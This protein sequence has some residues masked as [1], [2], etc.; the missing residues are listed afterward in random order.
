MKNFGNFSK[1]IFRNFKSE[2]L[3]KIL[4]EK[5]SLEKFESF[6]EQFGRILKK[7]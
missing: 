3:E 6:E 2:I 5:N 4:N 1:K 7:F